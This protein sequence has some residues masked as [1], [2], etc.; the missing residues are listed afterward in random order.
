M[1]TAQ[2]PRRMSPE[3][4]SSS[5]DSSPDREVVVRSPS[6]DQVVH[7]AS[8]VVE[9]DVDEET[10]PNKRQKIGHRW[11]VE[12]FAIDH[13]RCE[14]SLQDLDRLRAT[15]HIHASVDLRLHSKNNAPSRPPRGYVTIYLECFKWGARLPLHPY[16]A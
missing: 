15:Y 7:V 2:K 1:S 12:S 3:E 16:F 5:S 9:D 6:P 8:E 11:E 10:R 14:T 4:S 13:M